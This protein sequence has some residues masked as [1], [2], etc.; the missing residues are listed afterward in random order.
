MNVV[1]LKKISEV[2]GVSVS[3]VSRALKDHPDISALTKRKVMELA[4]SLE[5]EPNINAINL[6]NKH[7]MLFGLIV[8]TISR[9]FYD[10]FILSVEEEGRKQ[11]Y[12]LLILQTGENA[13][14]EQ[15][16]IR[17]CRQNRVAGVF[18]CL[19]ANTVDVEPY[20]RLKDVNIPVIFFDK[21]PELEDSIKVTAADAQAA[22]MAADALLAK[23][24]QCILA[25][26]GNNQLSITRRR[27]ASFSNQIALQKGVELFIEHAHNPLEATGLVERY[28][29]KEQKP[30]AVF[31]MSDEIL[32]GV[33]KGLQALHIN[34]PQETGVLALSNGFF[35]KL[36]YP[37]I[38]YVETSGYELGKLAFARMLQL[39]REEEVEKET[40]VGACLVEGGSL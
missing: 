36:Y 11:G 18:A 23:G 39:I 21:V 7:S 34:V 28:F 24:K 26:F 5:Y 12:S 32:T 3:T 22:S 27:I 10:S 9:Y 6:R 8:P 19:S 31:C 2:L 33:M 35:P 13:D 1:T 15:N 25:I 37:E 4:H 40:T 20:L 30:D 29:K 38:T 16:S 14:I 17:I